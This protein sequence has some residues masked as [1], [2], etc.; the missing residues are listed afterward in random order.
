[1]EED[2]VEPQAAVEQMSSASPASN[3]PRGPPA[4]SAAE[5][6]MLVIAIE[7]KLCKDAAALDFSRLESIS[8]EIARIAKRVATTAQSDATK[9]KGQLRVDALYHALMSDL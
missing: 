2:V 7:D 6:N 3:A 1:M 8:S 5:V 9:S 4:K